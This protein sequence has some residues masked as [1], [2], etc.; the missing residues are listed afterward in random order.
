MYSVALALVPLDST[1]RAV[2]QQAAPAKRRLLLVPAQRRIRIARSHATVARNYP[3]TLR[4]RNPSTHN[5]AGHPQVDTPGA[6]HSRYR[7]LDQ[8]PRNIGLRS[9]GRCSP[10][11]L[12]SCHSKALGRKKRSPMCKAWLLFVLLAALAVAGCVSQGQFLDSKQAMA[13]QTA[14]SP[15]AIRDELSRGDA[16]CDFA[17]SYPTLPCKVPG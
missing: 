4:P 11:A 3:K 7:P 13:M 9:N 14:V 6:S 8:S 17:R 12:Y 16:H 2:T 15:R 5:A 10:P 1:S